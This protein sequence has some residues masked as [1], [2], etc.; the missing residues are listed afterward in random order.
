MNKIMGID[1]TYGVIILVAFSA[2]YSIYGG[3]KAVAWTD[4]IQVVFLVGGGLLTTYLALD[5]VGGG[6][7]FFA[8][9][10]AL[11]EGA[12]EK[13]DMILEPEAI[14]IA[15]GKTL[16][17]LQ[18]VSP[19]LVPMITDTIQIGSVEQY[20]VAGETQYKDA[21][22]DLP[23]IA[24]LV[25]GM[26]IANLNYWGCN[27]YIIQRALAAKNTKEA[28]KGLAFAGYLKLL[29]PLIVVIPGIVAY[30]LSTGDNPAFNMDELLYDA[31]K[32][33]YIYDR[34]YPWLLGEY[35][36]PGL[37]GLAF[38]ALIAAVASSLS[39]MINS[40]S[41]IFTID[42]YKPHINKEASESRLVTI[43]RIVSTVALIIAAV[44]SPLLGTLDQAFQF[45][46]EFTGLISPG[47]V[48]IFLFG[49]FWKKQLLLPPYGQQYYQY[50]FLS[51]LN[52]YYLMYHL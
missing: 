50:L 19:D 44:I 47:V 36:G 52:F 31:D 40:I 22:N 29:L 37:K 23:G 8:G 49:L 51:L 35:V 14:Q 2:I 7:G 38:A 42:I 3:L 46:Q 10:S 45:I 28:Q 25:G 48:A 33:T 5:A 16:D 39:S 11:F 30:Q 20:V 18:T 15:T 12:P 6:Q 21:F 9:L 41:T 34:T 43:G 32:N 26:W 27:Q 17:T 1:Y 13:F 24:V 4:V